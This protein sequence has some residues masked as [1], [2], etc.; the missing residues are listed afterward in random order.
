MFRAT[1]TKAEIQELPLG[2]F[3]G[4]I[5]LI[6]S[7][8]KLKKC[9]PILKDQKVLGFDTETRPSF[10][11]GKINQVSLIQLSNEN[12]AFLIRIN[13][14]GLP[15]MLTD[16]LASKDVIKAGIAIKNDLR[17]L[18]KISP[19]KPQQIVELQDYIKAFNIQSNGLQSICAIVLNMRISKKQ[20]I[21]N[22][23]NEEL[24]PAQIKYAATDAWACYLIYTKLKNL[25]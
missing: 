24:T 19:F 4:E 1:I 25:L 10:K 17:V 2:F 7:I 21:S 13:K 18:R 6:D 20:Q 15:E 11:K 14:I 5:F 9:I 23:D 16:V 12:Q 8:K 22:W 3:N